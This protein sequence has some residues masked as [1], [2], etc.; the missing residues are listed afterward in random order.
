[1]FPSQGRAHKAVCHASCTIL[2]CSSC[3]M[4]EPDSPSKRK[5]GSQAL[6]QQ[7]WNPSGVLHPGPTPD[8][9]SWAAATAPKVF[10]MASLGACTATSARQD[11]SSTS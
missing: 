7:A 3:Y 1:M 6:W 4:D 2:Q 8:I 9:S 5:E 11:V 10:R